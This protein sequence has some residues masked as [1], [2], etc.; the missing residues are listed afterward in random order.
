MS[1]NS[2]IMNALKT[3]GIPVSFQTYKGTDTTYA[4]F[5]EYL[6]QGEAWAED[7]E[8]ITGHYVQV[9]I[10]SRGDNTSIVNQV[11]SLMAEAG[12]KRT[13]E[14]DLYEA[15][16]GVYHKGIRFFYAQENI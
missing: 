7:E 2:I 16:L 13:N 4:T 11:K 3:L 1:I 6:A 5:F 15:D 9:D 10:W 14:V 12:F 8:E